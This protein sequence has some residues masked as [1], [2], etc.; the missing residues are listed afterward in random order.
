MTVD[1]VKS[2]SCLR[3]F[4][5]RIH[6]NWAS[7]PIAYLQYIGVLISLA[8]ENVQGDAREPDVDEIDAGL[9]IDHMGPVAAGF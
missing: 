6:R 7:Q 3:P 1:A 9:R 8:T 2:M 5:L 4:D